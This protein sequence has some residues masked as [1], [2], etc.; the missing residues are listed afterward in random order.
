[1]TVNRDYLPKEYFEEYLVGAVS[2]GLH[3]FGQLVVDGA[4]GDPHLSGDFCV[5]ESVALAQEQD[6]ASLLGQAVDGCPE[7]RP[8]KGTVNDFF[9]G[10][11]FLQMLQVDGGFLSAFPERVDAAVV[12]DAIEIGFWRIGLLPALRLLPESD[13]SPLDDVLNCVS[14]MQIP[15]RI[16]AQRP[17]IHPEQIVYFLLS[18]H[19]KDAQR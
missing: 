18:H 6:L 15:R 11:V 8:D 16:Q 4:F 5:G 1:M 10:Y 13:K 9:I 14:I 2:E 12:D 19:A 17:V 7:P 3:G